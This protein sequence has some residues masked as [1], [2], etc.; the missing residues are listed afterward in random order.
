MSVSSVLMLA[1][2]AWPDIQRKAQ[3]EIDRVV[4]RSRFPVFSDRVNLPYTTAVVKETCRYV[5]SN[6]MLVSSLT[7]CLPSW[8][9]VAPLSE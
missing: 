4:G 8:R 6:S 1:L 7:R 5:V 2:T 9:P 3:E